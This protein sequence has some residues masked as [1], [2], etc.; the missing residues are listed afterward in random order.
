LRFYSRIPPPISNTSLTQNG[1]HRERGGE[2][3]HP[4]SAIPH[5]VP[6]NKQ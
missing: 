5:F 1:A 4:L 2:H 3:N 6:N